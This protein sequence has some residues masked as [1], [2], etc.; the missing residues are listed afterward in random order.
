MNFYSGI[1]LSKHQ[2]CL[3]LKREVITK[4]QSYYEFKRLI[5]FHKNVM[6][7][8]APLDFDKMGERSDLM[9]DF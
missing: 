6:L 7:S 1:R 4:K 8:Q 3:V 2:M 5:S 9:A